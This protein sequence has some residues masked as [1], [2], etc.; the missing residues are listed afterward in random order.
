MNIIIIDR[1]ITE[2]RGFQWYFKSYLLNKAE[3]HILESISQ[4]ENFNKDTKPDILIVEMELIHHPN[5]I[6]TIKSL[7]KKGAEVYAITAEPL[8]QH[9]LK[10]IQMQVSHFFVKPVDLHQ[11]KNL[12]NN[13]G[14]DAVS[15][16]PE[17]RRDEEPDY[18]YFQLF[19]GNEHVFPHENKLFF[20][21]EP[22]SRNDIVPLYKWLKENTGLIN[23][24]LYPLTK[25]I[26]CIGD[27]VDPIEFE[28]RAR[29]LMREWSFTNGTTINIAIYDGAPAS[30]N[31]TYT[32]TKRALYQ[33]FYKG[34]EHIFYVSKQLSFQPFDP[35]L[36]PE[37]Q[38]LWIQCLENRD[39]Q[40][41][42]KFLYELS[43]GS[44]Y[45]EED[46][47]RI[48]LTSVLAQIRRFMQKYSLHQ[49]SH[50][51][52]NYRQLFHII[53][54]HPILYT[55][56]QEMILFTLNVMKLA[57]H[58]SIQVKANYGE[59]AAELITKHYVNSFF[60]LTTAADLLGITPNYLSNVFSS[61]HGIPF[62]RYLQ[63]YRLAQ[64]QKT[65]WRSDLA[66]SEVAAA[67]GFED[68]NYF[69]KIFKQYA[70]LSPLR[71]R[72]MYRGQE[73]L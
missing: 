40:G 48:H 21:I 60:S 6:S 70:G 8:F 37:Q 65:L 57:S 5:D 16:T 47:I 51:E 67:N 28:S 11:L 71:Y 63:Q 23:L 25:R 69:S 1:D 10:A 59:L 17:V 58:E 33:R 35:L 2:A 3:V 62:K 12:I 55:I 15:A 53:L 31:Q 14:K 52:E 64:S 13:S 22:D 72:K 7:S 43:A 32:E 50:L 45:Y 19:A 34:F 44:V 42:K 61:Y 41:I 46:L 18:F 30:L 73:H 56:I 49:K 4:L 9:A 36:T 24:E 29:T 66:V 39:I 38:Q 27:Q 68:P 20:L 26:I 54:E